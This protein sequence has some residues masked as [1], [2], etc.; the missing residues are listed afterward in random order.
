[1]LIN[2]TFKTRDL[3]NDQ[4]DSVDGNEDLR[5]GQIKSLGWSGRAAIKFR[6]SSSWVWSV[7]DLQV[8]VDRVGGVVLDY[9]D[10][11]LPA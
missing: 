8:E 5:L 1:M 10:L 4:L 7:G 3:T 11:P 9:E 6:L 2:L